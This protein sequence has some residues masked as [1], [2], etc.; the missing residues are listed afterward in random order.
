MNAVVCHRC[1]GERNRQI[2]CCQRAQT[3]HRV[4]TDLGRS[5]SRNAEIAGNV[6]GVSAASTVKA[7]VGLGRSTVRGMLSAMQGD[8]NDERKRTE[9]DE[10][11]LHDQPELSTHKF[12]MKDAHDEQD[13]N[14]SV[15]TVERLYK[16]ILQRCRLSF[17]KFTHRDRTPA[18]MVKKHPHLHKI[19]GVDDFCVEKVSRHLCLPR[20]GKLHVLIRT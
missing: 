4:A 1:I 5:A 9:V 20:G 3:T 16:A 19:W 12:E 7:M 15:Q 11:T 13:L 10:G 2:E 6:I 18:V 8:N 14:L 17:T